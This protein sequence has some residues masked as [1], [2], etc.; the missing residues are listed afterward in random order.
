M[1]S[2]CY[3]QS[4]RVVFLIVVVVIIIIIIISIII[5]I[6]IIIFIIFIFIFLVVK[7]SQVSPK[8]RGRA[9]CKGGG[10]KEKYVLCNLQAFLRK[11]R[12]NHYM[13]Q[14][15]RKHG[16]RASHQATFLATI[17]NCPKNLVLQNISHFVS[18]V[19]CGR[20]QGR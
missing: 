11:R 8:A 14:K 18:Q 5:I 15:S 2:H 17:S 12:R 1:G 4:L 19:C 9:Q 7:S 10:G 16:T 13:E 6:I 3:H 20:P